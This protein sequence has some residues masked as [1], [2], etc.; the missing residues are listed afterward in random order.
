MAKS[1][2]NKSIVVFLAM[3]LTYTHT[4]SNVEVVKAERNVQLNGLVTS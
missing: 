3:A 2:F 4:F 1:L